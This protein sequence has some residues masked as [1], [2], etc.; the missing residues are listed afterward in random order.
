MK[1]NNY[2]LLLIGMYILSFTVMEYGNSNWI[3]GLTSLP[4]I[5]LIVLWSE[6]ITDYLKDGNNKS[7]SVIFYTDV[8]IINYSLI[9][10]IVTSLVFQRS[11]ADARGWWPVAIIFGE[12]CSI[13]L[14]VVF[15]TLALMLNKNHNWYTNGFAIA[16]F[17]GY[18]I[19]SLLP[20][21]FIY[22]GQT[23]GFTTYIIFLFMFHLVTCLY[24]K[25][26][27]R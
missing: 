23:N 21:R 11:N 20:W 24:Q 6:K 12:L 18:V 8:F 7:T 27:N 25:L 5:I 22:F 16:V 14:G 13:L 4:I 9:F 19:F 17:V 26:N 1:F 15:A 2:S 10:A 3:E